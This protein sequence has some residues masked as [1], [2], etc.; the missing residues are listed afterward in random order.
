MYIMYIYLQVYVY[1]VCIYYIKSISC[2]RLRIGTDCHLHSMQP[3]TLILL[4]LNPP[5]VSG[6]YY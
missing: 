1:M 5:F 4:V 2:L 3:L 6:N